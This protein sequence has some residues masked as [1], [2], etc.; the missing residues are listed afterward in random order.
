MR[1]SFRRLL[2]LALEENRAGNPIPLEEQ[3]GELPPAPRNVR[4]RAED[5]SIY[6]VDL[7]YEGQDAAGVHMWHAV[8]KVPVP[9][10]QHTLLIET[11]PGRTSVQVT[12]R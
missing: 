11:L 6:P 3:L 2:G 9:P 5:G 7:G 8:N 4:I 10:G 1:S 12:L